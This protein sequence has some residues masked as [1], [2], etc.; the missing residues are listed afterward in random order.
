MNV[1]KERKVAVGL[2][3]LGGIIFWIVAAGFIIIKGLSLL[4]VWI[5]G[6]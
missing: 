4:T 2:T 1:E 5:G 3:F 6:V